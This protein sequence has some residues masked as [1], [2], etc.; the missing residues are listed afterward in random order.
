MAPQPQTLSV[1][2]PAL[3][4]ELSISPV[5]ERLRTAKEELLHRGEVGEVELLVVDDGSTDRTPEIVRSFPEVRLIRHQVRQGY[6]A[7]LK[8]GFR[9]ARGQ[10]LAF[11][12]ADASYRPESLPELVHRLIAEQADLV[13]GSRMMTPRNGMPRIR[14]VGNWL[15][16][17]LLGWLVGRRITDSA[18]GMRVFRR[19]ALPALLPLPDGLHLTPVMSTR[20]LHEGL[21]LIEVP[22]PYDERAGRSKLS[23]IR[24]GLRFLSSI[25]TISRLYNPLKFFGWLGMGVL[26]AAFLLGI[27]P[28]THYLQVRRVEE[29][30]IYRLLTIMV[31]VVTGINLVTF[32]A[33]C[34]QVLAILYPS[35]PPTKGLWSRLLLR[36]RVVRS[37]GW[38]GGGCVLAAILLNSHAISQY[39]RTGHVFVHWSSIL[40]GAALFLTG[41]QLLMSRFLLTVLEELQHCQREAVTFHASDGTHP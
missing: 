26:V 25:L 17:R 19:S 33:F 37:A 41:A 8:T 23:V 9:H 11:L 39:L 30:A 22:I 7:A 6:G 18:S 24:D 13:I 15:F 38:V 3:N 21:R 27:G 29:T 12:D 4:E 34:N 5:L 20:A 16:A 32:G 36:Q 1:I 28:V 10:Y 40:T 35:R 31:L 14:Y 2:V